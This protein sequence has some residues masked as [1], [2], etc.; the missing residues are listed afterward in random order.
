MFSVRS[1][2]PFRI[3]KCARVVPVL[4]HSA[5]RGGTA[6]VRLLLRFGAA[7][8]AAV[9]GRFAKFGGLLFT[10]L[11]VA[12]CVG[13]GEAASDATLPPID[14]SVETET[15]TTT[16][17]VVPA[18]TTTSAAVV[19][20]EEN[21][22]GV[23]SVEVAEEVWVSA[24]QAA[25]LEASSVGDIEVFASVEVAEGLR[26][27]L[28]AVDRSIS[29]FAAVSEPDEDGVV[30]IHD[31]LVSFPPFFDAASTWYSGEVSLS[32]D[33]VPRVSS[34]S[35]ESTDPCVPAQ[36]SDAVIADYLDSR[37]AEAQFWG[38]SPQGVGELGEHF[39]G[40]RLQFVADLGQRSIAESFVILGLEDRQWNPHVFEFSTQGIEIGDCYEV[41][42]TFGTFDT[43]T[44]ERTDLIP[45]PDAGQ[46]N[47]DVSVMVF[48]DG[49]WKMSDNGGTTNIEC[50]FD[51]A[52]LRLA[53]IDVGGERPPL[54][55][56]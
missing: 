28:G 56:T 2:S 37:A 48:E 51:S 55:E 6:V 5:T 50:D 9:S 16:S 17:S 32:E 47:A 34:F 43:T 40:T 53:V 42:A 13:G 30:V 11:V 29:N 41:D 23:V 31:C 39:T 44:G 45:L 46:R 15:S 38:E 19:E 8:G 54:E 26:A 14:E 33:G 22:V 7:G 27:T 1:N 24:W 36:V 21:L 12:A 49:R 25:G 10:A 35:V 18:T 20:E 52:D 3:A 4:C